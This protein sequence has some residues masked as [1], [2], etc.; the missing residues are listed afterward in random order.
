MKRTKAKLKISENISNANH[1]PT[2]KTWFSTHSIIWRPIP[3]ESF[4]KRALINGGQVMEIKFL[5][6]VKIPCNSNRCL[7]FT[8]ICAFLS[9]SHTRN[10]FT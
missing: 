3:C 9:L 1:F 2:R 8:T 7:F 5:S 6:L 10:G 4:F